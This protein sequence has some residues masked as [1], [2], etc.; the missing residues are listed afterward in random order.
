MQHTD[1]RQSLLR[2][3]GVILLAV[4]PSGD[5]VWLAGNCPRVQGWSAY[6][7]VPHLCPAGRHRGGHTATGTGR[8]RRIR[9]GAPFQTEVNHHDAAGHPLRHPPCRRAGRRRARRGQRPDVPAATDRRSVHRQQ[10][11]HNV[12]E[13]A[14]EVLWSTY[15]GPVRTTGTA[16]VAPLRQGNT[17]V[18]AHTIT[19]RIGCDVYGRPADPYPA[20]YDQTVARNVAEEQAD[21]RPAIA[22]PLPEV[23][24]YDTVM[25]GS[26]VWNVQAPMI[27]STFIDAADLTGT[28]VLPF[29]TTPSAASA[30]P[31]TTTATR[32]PAR[33]SV[34]VRPCA[35]KPSL[36][37]GR[38]ST[39]GCAPAAAPLNRQPHP[40]PGY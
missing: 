33:R 34:P 9:H 37:P 30:V 2:P 7:S 11:A 10:P 17:E 15:P 29:G 36:T 14:G 8:D 27:M 16:P 20:S 6:R 32:L 24:R 23:G 5:P 19:K 38:T 28:R 13:P 26:P 21:A 12:H 40:A 35:G 1:L 39:D 22:H 18:L 25:L 31:R 4:A 3:A